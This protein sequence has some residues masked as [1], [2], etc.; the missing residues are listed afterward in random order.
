MGAV[1]KVGIWGSGGP[2]IVFWGIWGTPILWNCKIM[3]RW[4]AGCS[5]GDEV[6]DVGCWGVALR[7]QCL[8][9][10]LWIHSFAL[11]AE[12]PGC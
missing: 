2:F 4:K 9:F 8:G 3:R 1:S 10:G 5:G 7:S 11:L 6:R 12:G